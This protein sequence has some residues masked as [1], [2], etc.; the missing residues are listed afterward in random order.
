MKKKKYGIKRRLL[1][2][3]TISC[4]IIISIFCSIILKLGQIK[5]IKTE[6][7]EIELKLEGLSKEEEKVES[8]LEK[9]KDPDYVARYARE[10]YLYSKEDEFIIRIP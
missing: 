7:Q 3:G 1:F 9:L 5:D 4:V 10:K 8:K 6:K 2:F